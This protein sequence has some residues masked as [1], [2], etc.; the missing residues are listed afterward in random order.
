[1]R[2][3]W[4]SVTLGELATRRIDFTPVVG[5]DL[6][7]VVGVQ[8]SGWGLVDR[9][10][11]RGDS[12]KFSKL[13]ALE[14]GDLVYRTITAFE[15]PSTIVTSEFDDAFVTP[16]TF[17]TYAIDRS[18]ILPEFMKLLTTL[19][20]FHQAMSS[21]CVGSVLRRKT[22]S[23]TAF[24]SIPIILPPMNDQRRIVDLVE[25]VD[26]AVETAENESSA[27]TT[28]V[29]SLRLARLGGGMRPLGELLSSIDSGVSVATEGHEVTGSRL[30]RV[31][32][33]RHGVFDTREHKRVGEASLPL[34]ARVHN[35]DI[36]MTRSNTPD[37]V[38]YVAIADGVDDDFYMPDLVW[39]LVPKP[40]INAAYLV[41]VLSSE[42]GRSEIRARASGTSASMQKIS[43][44]R[45]SSIMIPV[46]A[47][48]DQAAY[49]APLRSAQVSADAARDMAA[50]LRVLR[51]NLLTVLMSGEHEIPKSYDEAMV[52]A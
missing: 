18:R 2:D 1:M 6:Y 22:L 49:V 19:P 42:Y 16:Q 41:E 45:I 12:M 3:E 40:E 33:V 31:S 7:R 51:S 21:R 10:P 38:G 20:S 32:A 47:L 29:E 17:P 35:G 4:C 50:A 13:L 27:Y 25:A 24:E 23:P 14:A 9:G 43:K 30:L 48:G 37:R 46:P 34:R 5:D 44:A 15:A 8:R 28:L 26:N 11:V 52:V 39:R 36:L